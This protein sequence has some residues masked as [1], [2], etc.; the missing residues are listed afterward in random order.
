MQSR[1]FPGGCI[2]GMI[3]ARTSRAWRSELNAAGVLKFR[4]VDLFY[5]CQSKRPQQIQVNPSIGVA[6]ARFALDH[7]IKRR[8]YPVCTDDDWL[9]LGSG[10][11]KPAGH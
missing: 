2:D 10:F 1:V 7:W 11:S 5:F 8:S 4:Y 9:G 6:S 3:K